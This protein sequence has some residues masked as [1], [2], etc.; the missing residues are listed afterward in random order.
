VNGLPAGFP[1]REPDSRHLPEPKEHPSLFVVGDYLFDSTL[2]GVL[3]SADVVAE[4]I[5]E[6][7]D[8]PV[9]TVVKEQAINV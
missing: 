7:L 5:L 8:E 3:D 4:W 9:A 2:N 6:E 1:A